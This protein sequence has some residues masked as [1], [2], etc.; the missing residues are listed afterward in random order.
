MGVNRYLIVSIHN[1]KKYKNAKARY[2]GMY[3][4]CYIGVYI[5]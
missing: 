5:F 3:C 2:N 1:I 4:I